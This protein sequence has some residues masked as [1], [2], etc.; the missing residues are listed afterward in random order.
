MGHSMVKWTLPIIPYPN[1]VWDF[2]GVYWA[3]S[4]N[5][6]LSLGKPWACPDRGLKPLPGQAPVCPWCPIPIPYGA[7]LGWLSGRCSEC[8]FCII[9]FVV[10][11]LFRI[12]S[13]VYGPTG[14]ILDTCIRYLPSLTELPKQLRVLKKLCTCRIRLKTVSMVTMIYNPQSEYFG[15]SHILTAGRAI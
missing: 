11:C 8:V 15:L 9:S 12:S 10:V 7:W 3:W 14:T 13:V 5:F 6:D 4:I 1:P 2:H